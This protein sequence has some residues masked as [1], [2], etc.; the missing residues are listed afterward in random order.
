MAL[1]RAVVST[2]VGCEGLDVLDGEHLLVA[3]TPDEFARATVRLLQEPALRECLCA[4]A[5]RL[6]ESR[7][8]WDAI[9]RHLMAVYEDMLAEPSRRAP[10]VS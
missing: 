8:D 9:A 6:V 2:T 4:N 5:R 10:A 3:D 7:Y 1:G